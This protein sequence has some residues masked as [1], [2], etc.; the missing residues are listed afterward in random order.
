MLA[1]LVVIDPLSQSTQ[2]TKPGGFQSRLRPSERHPVRLGRIR[3]IRPVGTPVTHGPPPAAQAR[4]TGAEPSPEQAAKQLKSC[5]W[6]RVPGRAASDPREG[7]HTGQNTGSSGQTAPARD[8]QGPAG[9]AHT[10]EQD[11]RASSR[12]EPPNTVQKGPKWFQTRQ[13]RGSQATVGALARFGGA[14]PRTR[15]QTPKGHGAQP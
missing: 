11:T 9:S 4:H 5:P 14:G 3:R 7:A 6:R 12:R 13:H 1:S 2:R 8:P 10:A 15:L